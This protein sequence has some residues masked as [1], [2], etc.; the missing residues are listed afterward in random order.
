MSK[1]IMTNG[2][3]TSEEQYYFDLGVKKGRSDAIEEF[4]EYLKTVIPCDMPQ[5]IWNIGVDNTCDR[6]LKGD[7]NMTSKEM[8]EK[9][10]DMI[11]NEEPVEEIE[12]AVKQSMDILNK[13]KAND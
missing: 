12:K 11:I 1:G 13:E 7:K 8:A 2:M 3:T 6:M 9:I 4:R 10:T 5:E